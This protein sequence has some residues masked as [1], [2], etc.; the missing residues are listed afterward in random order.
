[1]AR[2]LVVYRGPSE[3]DP[4]TIIRAVL[5]LSSTNRKTGD[6]VQLHIL[7]DSVAPHTAQQTGADSAVCGACPF[8]PALS[9]GCYVVTCQG[10]LST[11]KATRGAPVAGAAEVA[12]AL[13][14]R[15]LRLGAYGDPAALPLLTVQW[16]VAL[17]KGRATGYTH[18]WR[19]RPDLSRYCMASVESQADAL[20]AHAAGWRTFRGRPAGGV[21]MPNEI[22]CPSDKVT[23]AECLLCKGSS[24]K[25]RSI[26]IP[27]HGSKVG[28]ALTVV[29]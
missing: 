2:S 19:T 21:I 13:F 9:G 8:R 4:A 29:Q 14:G 16:L 18:G 11:W 15:T 12:R 26:T 28:R 5:V 10:P 23:C 25:A 20:E 7:H 22:D 17:V 24:S 3:Y 6:M 27:V 1:M